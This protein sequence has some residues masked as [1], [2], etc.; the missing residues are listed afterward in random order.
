MLLREF[1]KI[2]SNNK[3]RVKVGDVV[4]VYDEGL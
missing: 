4:L 3:L 2:I 1:Y